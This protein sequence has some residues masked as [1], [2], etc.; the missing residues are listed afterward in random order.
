MAE[1]MYTGP[2]KDSWSA[3]NNWAKRN[4]KDAA[5]NLTSAQDDNSFREN[6][7]GKEYVDAVKKQRKKELDE[8]N[9]PVKRKP[10]SISAK[11]VK[12]AYED[13]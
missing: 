3:Y 11:S 8:F 1:P 13:K 2:S 10:K 6:A 4:P 9:N 12:K 5:D 7:Y